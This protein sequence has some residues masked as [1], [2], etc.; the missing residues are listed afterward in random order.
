MKLLANAIAVALALNS[1]AAPPSYAASGPCSQVQGDFSICNTPEKYQ[2]TFLEVGLCETSACTQKHVLGTSSKAFDFASVPPNSDLGQFAPANAIIAPGSYAHLYMVWHGTVTIRGR[3]TLNRG[4]LGEQDCL[5][6]T[7][8]LTDPNGDPIAKGVW[9]PVG[10]GSPRDIQLDIL[11]GRKVGDGWTDTDGSTFK[12]MSSTEFRATQ[13]LK[14]PIVV[15]KGK[16]VGTIRI[17]F[18]VLEGIAANAYS[19]DGGAT[20]QCGITIAAPS[21]DVRVS[22]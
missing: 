17:A 7:S 19:R 10:Q 2:I 8:D 11:R 12:V 4:N 1:V 3:V 14:A 20:Y 18:N 22:N 15:E 21:S 9:K 5:T 16:P 13:P 6:S